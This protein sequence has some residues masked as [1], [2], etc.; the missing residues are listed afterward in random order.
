MVRTHTLVE[1]RRKQHEL[2]L[3]LRGLEK[4]QEEVDYKLDVEFYLRLE[5]L[6]KEHG[7]TFSQVFDLLESRYKS[8]ADSASSN[9]A[10]GR[11][12]EAPNGPLCL[13]TRTT[14]GLLDL[15]ERLQPNGEKGTPSVD[16]ESVLDSDAMLTVGLPPKPV[17]ESPVPAL[18]VEADSDEPANEEKTND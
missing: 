6:A 1:F 5:A 9:V 8:S 16:R 3:A 14:T 10:G 11:E 7:Y 17:V 15:I 12:A 4:Q 18:V 13:K 2:E